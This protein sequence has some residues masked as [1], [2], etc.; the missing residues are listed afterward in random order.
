MADV[1]FG[2]RAAPD[3]PPTTMDHPSQWHYVATRLMA[4]IGTYSLD[5][6][7]GLHWRWHQ[8]AALRVHAARQKHNIWTIP[9]PRAPRDTPRNTGDHSPKRSRSPQGKCHAMTPQDAT[10]GHH[11]VWLAPSAHKKGPSDHSHAVGPRQP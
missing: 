10:R 3:T 1:A 11:L 9:G 5:E 6:M 8:R 2:H 7:S 4:H